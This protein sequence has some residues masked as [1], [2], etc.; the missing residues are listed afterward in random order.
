MT[1]TMI[2]AE[3]PSAAKA[4]A[5]ALAEGDVRKIGE[6]N[7]VYFE[8]KKGGNNYVVVPA[9]GH[10]FTLKQKTKGWN[11]P[12]FDVDWV[13][14]YTAMKTAAFSQPYYE[15][16]ER[17]AREAREYIVATDYDDEG[18]VIGYNIIRFLCGQKDAPRM[19]F[20]T[21]THDELNESFEHAAK[22]MNKGLIES[23]LARHYLDW[24]W[25]INVT[26]A[27][28]LAIKAAAKRFKILSAGRVQGPTLHMLA[29]HEK[30]IKAFKRVP[31]WLIE[32][33]LK[34]GKQEIKAE[35]ER[36]K[37][38]KNSDAKKI[39]GKLKDNDSTILTIQKKLYTQKPPEPY[40]TTAFLADIYR[41]YGYSPQQGLSIAE[42]IYQAGL[43]SYPRTSSQKLPKNID[44][45]KI[46]KKL[47]KQKNYAIA[48]T[49][50]GREPTQG[51]REDAA[52]PAVYPT[53]E[54]AKHGIGSKQQNV[55]DLVVRRFLACFGEPAKRES[56][57]V[58]IDL[59]GEK[60][61]FVGKRTLEAGWTELYGKYSKREELILPELKEGQKLAITKKSLLDKKTEPPA[62][63]SQ[64]SV[65]K[66]MEEKNLGTKATRAS[67]LQTLYNRGYLIGSSI[68][69]TE[70]GSAVAGV[71]ERNMPD[72][73]SEKLTSHFEE[74][75]N[76]IENGKT[77]MEKVLAEAQK[78]L[79]KIC[80]DFKKKEK[81]VGEELTKSVIASQDR[82][83]ILGPCPKC[84]GTLKVHKSFRTKKR[85]VGC[86]GYKKGCRVGFPLPMIGLIMSTN[87]ICDTC[88]T[89]VIQV[90]R[91]VGRPFRMCLDPLCAT[92]KEWL[93]KKKLKKAKDD[94]IASKK[95]YDHAQQHAASMG[96]QCAECKQIFLSKRGLTMH[97]KKA[98]AGSAK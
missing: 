36:D 24:Y 9:V 39:F 25:G 93:D 29:K 82:Q 88:K 57:K 8:F 56:Q 67:I 30:K 4:I 60:F 1:Y 84:G 15:N 76:E 50:L 43:I 85:F 35:Y 52:H 34:L 38:W 55:Y 7:T 80:N 48:G 65:L 83:S 31:F 2:I 45:D 28:T 46:L 42:T 63:Y 94:S 59:N 95:E 37:I 26:R 78:T 96:L 61:F 23:G 74:E 49:L 79:T 75:T 54:L 69:V 5:S 72:V 87:K 91:N 44:Y 14:S 98:H 66:A 16:M 86:S 41:Y 21:M 70:L 51:K 71:L 12:A 19:K 10:L 18:E 53:G 73:I 33:E 97:V 32:L 17:V 77:T 47:A 68:E 90:R 64:G 20:S 89:P 6:K 58:T 27:L 13:P 11:Y 3:K 81:K 40:N 92:K 62:R 22:H